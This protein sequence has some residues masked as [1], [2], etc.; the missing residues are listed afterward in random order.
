[1]DM[2]ETLIMQMIKLILLYLSRKFLDITTN[3]QLQAG[4]VK[5]MWNHFGGEDAD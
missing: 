5:E 2:L 1:M 3:Q 4:L